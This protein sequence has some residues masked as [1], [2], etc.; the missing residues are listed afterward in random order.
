MFCSWRRDT[1]R[2]CRRERAELIGSEKLCG[3]DLLGRPKWTYPALKQ[4]KSGSPAR[5]SPFLFPFGLFLKIFVNFLK[6]FLKCKKLKKMG[7]NR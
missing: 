1:W 7:P 4:P 2:K 3:I 5:F 6:N